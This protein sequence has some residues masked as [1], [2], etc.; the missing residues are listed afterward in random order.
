MKFNDSQIERSLQYEY[1]ISEK[2]KIEELKQELH[3]IDPK[4]IF[5]DYNNIITTKKIDNFTK[6]NSIK[7]LI[8]IEFLKKEFVKNYK[9]NENSDIIKSIF[10]TKK[11][12]EHLED[13]I[14]KKAIPYFI[15][16]YIG[17]I[18]LTPR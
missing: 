17:Y 8:T 9:M 13:C 18:Y 14:K 10:H 3:N 1:E 15:L 11:Y 4:N 7:D 5:N 2:Y 12:Q 16:V 6:V